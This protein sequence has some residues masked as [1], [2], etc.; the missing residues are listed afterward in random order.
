MSAEPAQIRRHVKL[1]AYHRPARG[2]PLTIRSALC[3]LGMSVRISV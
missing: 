3:V 1:K 2:A